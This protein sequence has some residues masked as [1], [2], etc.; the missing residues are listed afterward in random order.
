[1]AL[2]LNTTQPLRGAIPPQRPPE[3]GTRMITV[4]IQDHSYSIRHPP[5]AAI[6]FLLEE[7]F[8]KTI[9]APLPY[10]R[11][12]VILDVGANIG[13]A[14][15]WFRANYPEA[16]IYAFEPDPDVYQYLKANTNS[17]PNIGTYNY[18]CHEVEGTI[19]L[20]KGKGTTLTGTLGKSV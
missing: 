14:S 6:G 13:C 18:G 7:I 2:D 16:Q 5:D 9:Y 4:K 19:R 3:A 17:L 20:F 10:L 8:V 15:I 1:V 12:H 11:P